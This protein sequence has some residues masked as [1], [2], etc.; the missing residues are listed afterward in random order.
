MIYVTHLLSRLKM[1]KRAV[2]ALEYGLIAAVLGTAI[3]A[4]F[5]ILGNSLGS[6]FNNIADTL[7]NTGK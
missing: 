1:D 2:T 3:V 4:A 6:S 7:N 5:G